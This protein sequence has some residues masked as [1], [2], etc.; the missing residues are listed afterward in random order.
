MGLFSALGKVVGKVAQVGLSKVTHG[1]SDQVLKQLKGRGAAKP[2]RNKLSGI[3]QE[4]LVNKLAPMSPRVVRTE[5][6]LAD[7]ASNNASW[8]RGPALRKRR[9][10]KPRLMSRA[11]ATPRAAPRKPRGATKAKRGG[12]RRPPPGGLDLKAMG[13]QYRAAGKPISWAEWRATYPIKRG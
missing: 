1:L 11:T 5:T 9:A 6:V 13:A 4:A 12:G 8:M 7:A 2:L 3:Q 10:G